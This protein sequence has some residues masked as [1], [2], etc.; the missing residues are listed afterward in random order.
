ML[1][2]AELLRR[3]VE[4]GSQEAFAELV[5]RHLKLVHHSALRRVGRNAHAADDVTQA[6]FTGLA[7]KAGSLQHH[8]NLAGWLYTATRF[9]AADIVRSERR[10]R[11]HEQEAETMKELNSEPAIPADRLEPFLDEALDLMDQ[12]DREAVLLHYF[13]GH[14]FAEVGAALS[15]SADAARMRVN[16]ALDRLRAEFAR[17]GV[18]S[19][20]A[21]LAAALAVQSTLAVAT[22]SVLAVAG[23]AVSE[24]GRLAKPGGA[25]RAAAAGKALLAGWI[26]AALILGVGGLGGAWIG[27]H[28]KFAPPPDAG[29]APPHPRAAAVVESDRSASVAP[30]AASARADP[31]PL[32]AA[33]DFDHLSS[34]EKN[35]LKKL[36]QVRQEDGPHMGLLVPEGSPNRMDFEVG[37]GLLE[38]GGYVS[39]G[40]L[41]GAGFTAAGL[42]FCR[43]NEAEID[44]YPLVYGGAQVAPD[45]G[46]SDLAESERKVLKLLWVRQNLKFPDGESRVNL[47][48]RESSPRAAEWADGRERLLAL[49]LVALQP[50]DDS[51][52]HLSN[53]GFDYCRAHQV[54][55]ASQAGF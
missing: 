12:R 43:R 25:G 2:D 45:V 38:Q 55:I 46:F 10:R 36:W 33:A 11:T 50:T 48:L 40:P 34:S 35:V 44:A 47:K 39:L 4:S 26:P 17:R 15:L 13:E 52:I 24:A 42:D 20:A 54:E 22:P 49:G 41:G 19:S 23:R 31:G 7:R 21:A 3:Y 27:L 30:A 32:S 6:V 37:R 1:T 14:T 8:P 53:A 29:P 16:R 51:F 9:A 5:R 28:E 18:A